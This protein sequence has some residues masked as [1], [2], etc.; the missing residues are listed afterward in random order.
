MFTKGWNVMPQVTIDAAQLQALLDTVKSQDEALKRSARSE[1]ER[2]REEAA[3][4]ESRQ[5]QHSLSI[6]AD[7][8]DRN[9]GR[10][11]QED[12]DPAYSN[13]GRH[14][15]AQR[16]GETSECYRLRLAS[17]VQNCS[18]DLRD[19]DLEST[20]LRQ[21]AS[22]RDTVLSQIRADAL[23][24]TARHVEIPEGEIREFVRKDEGGR[25]IH[26]F[27][28]RDG[29]TFIQQMARPR[30]IVSWIYN[31]MKPGDSNRTPRGCGAKIGS[32]AYL[33]AQQLC[34]ESGRHVKLG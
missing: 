32:K 28:S 34:D 16:E 4:A 23:K 15:P 26:E 17:G 9:R 8:E 24:P 22:F 5:R 10:R 18:P 1:S 12:W 3:C 31:K 20:L 21:P 33:T 29:T 11:Y 27:V 19:L 14:A 13:L 7:A 6:A 30:Q 25:T 2:I